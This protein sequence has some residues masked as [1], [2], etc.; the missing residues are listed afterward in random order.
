VTSPGGT[1]TER[2]QLV[3][4]ATTNQA[5]ASFTRLTGAARDTGEAATRSASSVRDAADRLAA[6]RDREATAAGAL[7]VAETR[8]TQLR[9]G[10]RARADQLAAAEERVASAQRG[11]HLA[12]RNVQR[13]TD[14]QAETQRRATTQMDE[15]TRSGGRLSGAMDQLKERGLGA[16]AALGGAGLLGI[17]RNLGGGFADSARDAGQLATSMNATVGQAGAF[18]G[19]V[20]SLGLELNDLLEIQAEFAQKVQDNANDFQELGAQTDRNADGTVNWANTLVGFLEKLQGVE[21]ATERNRLGFQF[22]GEEGYKQMSRLVASG[23]SVRDALEQI[24]TPITEEDV[25]MAAEYDAAML[26]LSLTSTRTQQQ[27]GRLL[28]PVLAGIAEG[29]G[30]VVD[31]VEEVPAPLALAT[32]AAITLGITGF[33]PTAVAGARLAAVK[34]VLTR[35]M[36]LYSAAAATGTRATFLL[37]GSMGAAAGAGGAMMAFLGGPLGVSLIALGAAYAVITG[38]TK[39]FQEA[40]REGAL[41]LAEAQQ[42]YGDMAV[43][44]R[45]LGQQ[46][47]EEA[48]VWDGLAGSRRAASNLFDELGGGAEFANDATGGLMETLF[49][50]A[51]QLSG[52]EAAAAGYTDEIERQRKELGAYGAQSELAQRAQKGLNDLIAEGTTD[53]QEFADAVETAA[54]AQAA[55]TRTS[56]LAAAAIS[57]YNAVTR[58]AV[59]TQ[60]DLYNATLAQSDGLIGLQQTVHEAV[61]VVDDLST[62]WNEVA[63]ATN[64]VISS[65]LQ[66]AGTAADAAV[67]V[68]TAN[69]TV[70]DSLTEAQ[71]RGD[72]T[73][74]ALRESLNAPGLTDLARSQIG[75]MITELETAQEAGDIEAILRLTGADETAG[76]LDEATQDREAT[77]RVESRGGPAVQR[78]LDGLAE[79]RLAI[80]RVESRNGPAVGE[81]LDRLALERLAIIR[82]ES[83]NGP[84][85]DEYL[86]RLASQARTAY[87]DVRERGAGTV[88]GRTGLRNA[89][90][91]MMAAGMYGEGGVTIQHQTVVVQAD[92][93]GRVTRQ[94]L[95]EAGRETVAAIRA[96][97][98]QNGTRWRGNP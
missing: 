27:L 12:T 87:I 2:L 88:G 31:V 89:P 29:I 30:D 14:E 63:E 32:A 98:R 47:A 59:Q 92:P 48:G 66:Y 75:S 20:G 96:Y 1:L 57:A 49:G 4:D 95:A 55:E 91:V 37:A 81:Y 41:E 74:S 42:K 67:A 51:D 36:A 16:A 80:I 70:V 79:Q 11:L 9:E 44:S 33:N 5:E 52:G 76:E 18:L 50:V 23:T 8:L 22:L 86:D 43:T 3:V 82:V 71:L 58:D 69:G 21:D 90:G 45:E 97:E 40:A 35:E 39:D 61:D 10:G 56:D 85:V 54:D 94:S 77:V 19:L 15:G 34:A 53:G 64:K 25:A 68:A 24:G 6:A 72:A 65:A 13:A 26:D 60:V 46:L 73:I 38:G 62:P 28:L 83:R 93:S 7:R 84:A 17:L 78:Y